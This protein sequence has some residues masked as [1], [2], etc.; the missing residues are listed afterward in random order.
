MHASRPPTNPRLNQGSRR[1]GRGSEYQDQQYQS[2]P[3][4]TRFGR[5]QNTYALFQRWR[6][7]PTFKYEVTAL[8]GVSGGCYYANLETVPIT[9]RR[10][11]NIISEEKEKGYADQMYRQVI[12]EYGEKILPSYDVRT[13][14]VERVLK[15]LLPS[16]EAMGMNEKDWTVHVIEDEQKNAFVIPG[17][18]GLNLRQQAKR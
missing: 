12:E 11:F 13:Q 4:Y 5:A 16:A 8:G 7:R 1:E 9:Q 14:R 18:V 2:R 6:A 10:R 3:Q 17:S 15:R